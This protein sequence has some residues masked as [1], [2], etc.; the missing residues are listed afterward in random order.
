MEQPPGPT[1]DD[2][3]VMAFPPRVDEVVFIEPV[4]A[5]GLEV[6]QPM[7]ARTAELLGVSLAPDDQSQ[8][9]VELCGPLTQTL[10]L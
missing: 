2:Q 5:G 8:R 3:R 6:E 4:R 10:T 1:L 9:R 7:F